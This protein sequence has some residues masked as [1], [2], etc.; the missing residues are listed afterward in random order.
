MASAILKSNPK[1]SAKQI[2]TI[3]LLNLRNKFFLNT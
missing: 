1:V 3:H 2:K